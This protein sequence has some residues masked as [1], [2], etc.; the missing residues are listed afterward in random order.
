MKAELPTSAIGIAGIPARST[1]LKLKL[2]P[3][4][5]GERV[6]HCAAD[7]G[8]D[9]IN[10]GQGRVGVSVVH[11]CLT[12]WRPRLFVPGVNHVRSDLFNHLS[13]SDGSRH[14]TNAVRAR[15]GCL[16]V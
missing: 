4:F 1:R 11:T 14:A 6:S 5:D 9:V 7:M 3:P 8:C 16:L 10:L 13:L 15:P 2:C 12:C